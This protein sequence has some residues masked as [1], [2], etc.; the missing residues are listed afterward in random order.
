[1]KEAAYCSPNVKRSLECVH[2]LHDGR[3]YSVKSRID[4]QLLMGEPRFS[5]VRP[6]S[7]DIFIAWLML[8]LK[9][10]ISGERR[11]RVEQR[12]RNARQALAACT[13]CFLGKG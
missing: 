9:T 10:R 4:L 2:R 8:G 3:E 1:M 7:K 13:R 11:S 6:P 5:Q 12:I